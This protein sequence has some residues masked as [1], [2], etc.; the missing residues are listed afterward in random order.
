MF[1]F[2]RDVCFSCST[3]PSPS[4]NPVKPELACSEP[5]LVAA[6]PQQWNKQRRQILQ[7]TTC[8]HLSKVP[9]P[10]P[11]PGRSITQHPTCLQQHPPPPPEPQEHTRKE[12]CCWPRTDPGCKPLG[13]R[14]WLGLPP[15]PSTD[16]STLGG[17]KGGSDHH[18]L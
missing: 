13:D 3:L 11:S 17:H 2:Q 9:L 5:Q 6:S 14:T 18:E 10:P 15:V 16:P 4:K 7:V 12:E 1:E 8:F